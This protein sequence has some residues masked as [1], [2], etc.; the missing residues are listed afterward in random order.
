MNEAVA[1]WD[2]FYVIVGSSAAALTGLMFVVITLTAEMR[3]EASERNTGLDAY[4]SPTVLHF[5]LVLL[6]A[7]VLTSPKH[8]PTSIGASLAV[9]ALF[10]LG[11]MVPV[12]LR[13]RR[14][15]AYVPVAEDWI[16]HIILPFV[17]Y[18]TLATCAV[19]LWQGRDDS[20][21]FVGAAALLLLYIGIHNAWD[22]ATWMA[23]HGR[24]P[25]AQ[26]QQPDVPAT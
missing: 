15:K 6:L 18:F 20:L 1:G 21:Y 23:V 17:A 13:M 19:F 9:V 5:C 3:F 16:W 12:L 11:Y 14:V 22:T 25:Q 24:D 10:G 2:T 4:A 26:S 8:T 7:A